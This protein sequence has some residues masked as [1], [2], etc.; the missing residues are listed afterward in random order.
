MTFVHDNPDTWTR[1]SDFA[2]HCDG[3]RSTCQICGK[4]I[5]GTSRHKHFDLEHFAEGQS[6]P[7]S[8]C[9]KGTKGK[10]KNPRSFMRHARQEHRVTC[11]WPDC[12]GPKVKWRADLFDHIHK[13]HKT[14]V[15]CRTC[16]KTV[17]VD[18]YLRH[19][20]KFADVKNL[21]AVLTSDDDFVDFMPS[22]KRRREKAAQLRRE[23]SRES[24]KEDLDL[25]TSDQ[26]DPLRVNVNE[27]KRTK[28]TFP[29]VRH[30]VSE[31]QSEDH[32]TPE[33]TAHSGAGE[34]TT[35]LAGK[36]QPLAIVYSCKRCKKKSHKLRDHIAHEESCERDQ[37]HD[38][39]EDHHEVEKN[40]SSL[41]DRV[42]EMDKRL[43]HAV[44]S[45]DHATGQRVIQFLTNELTK[46]EEDIQSVRVRIQRMK[47][48]GGAQDKGAVCVRRY[49]LHLEYV[50][51]TVSGM[52]RKIHIAREIFP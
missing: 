2:A 43:D 45:G 35:D 25:I 40:L 30:A 27:R 48:A 24:V 18:K 50:T 31:S 5:V 34:S 10:F 33:E 42:T 37:S 36:G 14:S 20:C 16:E 47:E 7:C 8:Q 1:D 6:L 21:E 44:Q 49:Q 52:K 32:A 12:N 51:E 11:N 26:N 41:F 29:A 46:K 38:P 39:C 17:S 15:A 9:K 23:A 4:E 13:H 22:Q 28:F 3:K 19:V